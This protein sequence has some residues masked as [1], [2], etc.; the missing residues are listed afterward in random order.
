MQ[1]KR[2]IAEALHFYLDLGGGVQ[3]LRSVFA[4]WAALTQ[5]SFG[6]IHLILQLKQRLML[7]MDTL[8]KLL[9]C[10]S[11]ESHNADDKSCYR[12]HMLGND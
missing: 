4:D 7:P 9:V 6:H 2:W 12:H 8:E 11:R 3:E 10:C 1:V 5:S